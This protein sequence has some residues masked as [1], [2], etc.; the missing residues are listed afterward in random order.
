MQ[1]SDFEKKSEISSAEM[2]RKPKYLIELGNHNYIEK[3][4][5][6]LLSIATTNARAS[7]S[8]EFKIPFRIQG[9]HVVQFFSVR[10][11]AI[12]H[13]HAKLFAFRKTR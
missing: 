8:F 6:K 10:A 7:W 1:R 2:I 13:Q 9:T 3:P 4:V 11:L 12:E 5:V